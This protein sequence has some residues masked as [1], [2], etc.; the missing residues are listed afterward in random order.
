MM[1]MA[2]C[3][4]S[5]PLNI[6]SIYL[7]RASAGEVDGAYDFRV[8]IPKLDKSLILLLH[9]FSCRLVECQE[10]MRYASNYRCPNNKTL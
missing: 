4:R 9:C 2:F 6:P 10:V 5:L 3:T 8:I 1:V 7:I